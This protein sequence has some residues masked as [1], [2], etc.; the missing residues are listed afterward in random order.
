MKNVSSCRLV[1]IAA[2]LLT[3]AASCGNKEPAP[4]ISCYRRDAS[5]CKFP[6]PDSGGPDARA[7]TDGSVDGGSAT[8]GADSAT[9]DARV[10]QLSVDSTPADGR[11]DAAGL[12]GVV[13]SRADG[14]DATPDA[15]RTDALERLDALDARIDVRD[16]ADRRDGGPDLADAHTTDAE[17]A[18]DA[19]ADGRE[20]AAG[21]VDAQDDVAD[22]PV[23][24]DGL[25][26]AGPDLVDAVVDMAIP[27]D[28]TSGDLS[29][30]TCPSVASARQY[31]VTS[32]GGLA[33]DSTGAPYI[34][35]K[36]FGSADF[37]AGE[38]TSA[39]S[40]DVLVAKLDP[41][42]LSATWS[43]AFG[44][45]GESSNPTDQIPVA[46][47]VSQ[48]GQVGVLGNFTGNLVVKAG[49]TLVGGGSAIDFVMAT[50][51]A[52]NGLWGK[53]VDTQSG[54]LL[55]MAA[56][57]ARDEFAVCGYA[58]G[59][60]TSLGLS[61]AYNGDGLEDIVVAKLNAATG[62]VMWARQLGGEGT[63]LCSAIAMDAAGTVYAA[64]A[65]NG[66]L[67]F[68]TGPLP[69]L[70]STVQAVWVAKF[71]TS[72]G[73]ALTAK[74]YG[75]L[76]KQAAKGIAVA[77]DGSVAITGNMKNSLSFGATTLTAAGGT[78]GYVAKLDSN[79]DPLWATNWGDSANQEA[80]RV[81][82]TSTGDLLVVGYLKGSAVLAS[83]TLTSAGL[84]DAYW[85][86]FSGN[87]A[88][89]CAAVYGDAERDQVAGNLAIAP[90]AQDKVVVA[91]F[92][93]GTITFASGL[94]L[95][96]D[97]PKGFLFV[98]P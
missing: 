40:S 43:K 73:S 27:I 86:R 91:G 50:D 42:T 84:S 81:A 80:H 13:D 66:T 3:T 55:A 18:G 95:T 75:T 56:H 30:V 93:T 85:A 8:D 48:S 64:G 16:T 74:K 90:T 2:L 65:Y 67:D 29:P 32:I 76:A 49:T 36:L 78:D 70:A 28:T 83:S 22:V 35:A 71:D 17:P 92:S 97:T 5:A 19:A 82:V 45:T 47:A 26:A 11:A 68:G 37:G 20:D 7:A 98:L 58:M 94:T 41:S 61:G 46:A 44:G 54:G 10:D 59:G 62:D 79:L 88:S 12:D 21:I 6:E 52:G 77:H 4:P 87:G 89:L 25:D 63:Q 57:P 53:A 34:V 96:S 51:S 60:V 72:T 31:A 1:L 23:S 9:P 38:V 24:Q 14:A 15:A 33:M 39:G 69:T